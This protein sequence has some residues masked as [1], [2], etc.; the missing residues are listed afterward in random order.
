MSG[1]DQQSEKKKDTQGR[2]EKSLAISVIMPAYNEEAAITSQIDAI[3]DV[4]NSDSVEYELIVVDD[5]SEDGTAG[6][7]FE[8]DVRVLNHP[9][10]RGYG[11]ALKTGIDAAKYDTVVIIDA[12]GTYPADAI[13]H[14]IKKARDYDMVVGA[15]IGPN[16]HISLTRKPAKWFL[17]KLAGYLAGRN[18][19]DLNSGLR[20]MKKSVV[21]KFYGILPSGYSFT[22]TITLAFYCNDYLIYYY[23]IDY[24]PRI[25]QSKIRPIDA[26]HFLLLV[27]RTIVYFNPLKVFLP[28]GG[29]LFV[30]GFG[31]FVY[32][33]FLRNLSE[34][35][36]LGF[37]GGVIIWAIGLL[38]DQIAKTGLGSRT[39]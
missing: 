19:P 22:T 5:G 15:R 39:K 27:L 34:S 4:L 29:I 17:Q 31:K 8:A 6:K 1:I 21:Q 37:L 13:P 28:L 38:S 12:D 32:D 2:S 35:A 33:L 11:A 23:P 10:N 18:I 20:V 3:R 25:G 14:L 26:Y 16:V 36:I 7:A 30:L 9:E 24:K